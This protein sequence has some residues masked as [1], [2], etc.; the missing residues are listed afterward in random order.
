MLGPPFGEVY[1]KK[2]KWLTLRQK[3]NENKKHIQPQS[4]KQEWKREREERPAFRVDTGTHISSKNDNRRRQNTAF[5]WEEKEKENNNNNKGEHFRAFFDSL[6]E[7]CYT[8][9]VIRAQHPPH[10]APVSVVTA[11][12]IPCAQQQFPLRLRKTRE[13]WEK[14]ET[15]L[16]LAYIVREKKI[17]NTLTAWESGHRVSCCVTPTFKK[18][19]KRKEKRSITTRER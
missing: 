2:K 7:N 19:N 5:R 10:D 16:C 14:G 6:L 4:K 15:T 8:S 18:K 17:W 12:P 9:V 13:V 11:F 1:K 3:K